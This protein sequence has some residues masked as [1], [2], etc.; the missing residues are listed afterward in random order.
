METIDIND[1][2]LEDFYFI[3]STNVI[4][5]RKEKKYGIFL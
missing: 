2:D 5:L 4:R 3:I 1:D